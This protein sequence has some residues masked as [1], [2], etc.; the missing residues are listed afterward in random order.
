MNDLYIRPINASA[1]KDFYPRIERDFAA[2]EY[3]PMEVLYN[4]M[5]QGKQ[6]GYALWDGNRYLAYSFCA[7]NPA[8]DHILITLFAVLAEYRGQGIGTTF[9]KM[10]NKKFNESIIIVEVEKPEEAQTEEERDKRLWRIAFYEKEGYILIN[11]IAYIIWDIPMHLMVRSP[12]INV[13]FKHQKIIKIMYQ[14]YFGLLGKR[15]INKMQIKETNGE[16]NESTRD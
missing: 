8:C 16:K 4:H 12:K 15:F 5:L 9:L 14:I 6:E 7:A 3:P 11:G 2:G 13:P 1:L 10:M